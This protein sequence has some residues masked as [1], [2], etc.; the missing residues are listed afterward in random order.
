MIA[1]RAAQYRIACLE[2]VEHGA[3]RG[4]PGYL[5]T[6][7]AV[8]ARECLQMV[9]QLDADHGRLWTST[10][11]TGGKSR[12]IA[13]QLSPPSADAYTCPPVVPK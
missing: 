10:E 4:G 12:T 5:D 1:N 9:W 11:S 2:R 8:H 13:V 7:F 3:R 6:H